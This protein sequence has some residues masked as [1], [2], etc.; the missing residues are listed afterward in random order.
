MIPPLGT[1]AAVLPQTL[2]PSKWEIGPQL[3]PI[4]LL[5]RR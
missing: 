1:A 4:R 2:G 5:Q 3:S